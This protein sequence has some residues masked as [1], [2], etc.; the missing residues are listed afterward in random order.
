MHSS[1]YIF[2]IRFIK[3]VYLNWGVSFS[4]DP[5]MGNGSIFHDS[6]Q[7]FYLDLYVLGDDA[8]IS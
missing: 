1:H 6:F 7:L 5:F 2:R 4:T 8:L 3:I